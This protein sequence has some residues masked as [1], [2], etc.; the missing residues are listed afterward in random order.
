MTTPM[1]ILNVILNNEPVVFVGAIVGVIVFLLLSKNEK[2]E[3]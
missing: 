2:K 3:L 1:I